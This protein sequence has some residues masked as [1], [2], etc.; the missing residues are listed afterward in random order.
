MIRIYD[1]DAHS[2]YAQHPNA[3]KLGKNEAGECTWQV[4]HSDGRILA[5][6]TNPTM[7]GREEDI[8]S[9]ERG[10]TKRKNIDVSL[11]SYSSKNQV[12]SAGGE[13]S[14]AIQLIERI[15]GMN[16]VDLMKIVEGTVNAERVTFVMRGAAAFELVKRKLREATKFSKLKGAGVD[17]ICNELAKEI[18]IDGKTLY[19]DYRIFEEFK[20]RLIETLQSGPE[21]LLPREM[22]A[23]AVGAE[24]THE[25]LDYFEEQR[26]TTGG[27]FTDHARRDVKRLNEGMTLDEVRELDGVERKA[28]A[29]KTE[30]MV[31]LQLAATEENNFYVAQIIEKHA[32]FSAWFTMRAKEEFGT[33]K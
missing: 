16:S 4:I 17:T 33:P 27:Y 20:D 14:G 7:Q 8:S 19:K 31:T 1:E 25:V 11:V 22:Y 21:R 32:S 18:G 30:K 28:K 26:E 29:G 9:F 6:G 10:K 5:E 12:V 15:Q 2:Y 3:L 24:D 23:V 13:G